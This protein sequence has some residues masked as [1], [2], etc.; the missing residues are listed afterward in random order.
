M[1]PQEIKNIRRYLGMTQ[2][3][4]AQYMDISAAT[5]N[6]WETGKFKPSNLAVDKIKTLL[7]KAAYKGADEYKIG[8][9][10]DTNN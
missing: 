4:F 3:K 10:K 6:R 5:V 8:Q 9:H 2:E 7:K 1:E